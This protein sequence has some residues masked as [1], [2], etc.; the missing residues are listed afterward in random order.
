M[1]KK[2]LIFLLMISLFFFSNIAFAGG[3]DKYVGSW[4]D[5]ENIFLTIRLEDGAPKIDTPNVEIWRTEIQNVRLEGSALIF[6]Q[7]HYLEDTT[8]TEKWG[9][10]PYSGVINNVELR[11]TE[12]GRMIYWMWTDYMKDPQY[13]VEVFRMT[14]E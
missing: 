8:Y 10:H 1:Y 9:E 14:T 4:G 5:K 13:K 11:E 12:D 3:Y 2:L 7:I 6:E